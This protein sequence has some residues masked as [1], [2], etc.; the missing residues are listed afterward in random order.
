MTG[1]P[2]RRLPDEPGE[3]RDAAFSP[4]GTRLATVGDD[5]TV[6]VRDVATLAVMGRFERPGTDLEDRGVQPGRHAHRRRPQRTFARDVR[7][8]RRGAAARRDPPVAAAPAPHRVA[9]AQPAGDA[10]RRHR[11]LAPRRSRS[12]RTGGGWPR[13]CPPGGSRC[14]TWPTRRPRRAAWTGTASGPRRGRSAPDGAVL[15][16]S[17]DDRRCG[18]GAC[19]T[20]GRR[21]IA[22]VGRPRCAPSRSARTALRSPRP[23]RTRCCGCGAMPDRQPLALIDRHTYDLND[24]AFD[25]ERPADQLRRRR[26]GAGLGPRPRPRRPR[27]VRR[28]RPGAPSPTTGAPSAPTWATRPAA[29][30]EGT[31]MPQVMVR[32]AGSPRCCW[33]R[34]SRWRSAGRRTRR[35]P[36]AAPGRTVLTLPGLR[37][38][39][40]PAGR[41]AGRRR[42]A[43]CA[44]LARA[45]APRSWPAC[46]TRPAAPAGCR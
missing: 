37:T 29:R 21:A 10:T 39:R 41:R 34:G 20:G 17:G 18:C 22:G 4:D 40:V 11:Q 35:R 3:L 44:D 6:R 24:V 28:A 43:G 23:A 38:A 1:E 14:G 25:D 19:R 31:P 5:G 45:P 2:A 26:H 27:A 36:G 30:A 7:A 42:R 46:S 16:T 33:D 32:G 15:A 9:A 8:A 12:A 13:R